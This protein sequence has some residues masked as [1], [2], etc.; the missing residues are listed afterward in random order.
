[1]LFG[2]IWGVR[3]FDMLLET[4]RESGL[5]L[6]WSCPMDVRVAGKYL[7]RRDLARSGLD[8]LGALPEEE[9]VATLRAA[10]FVVVTSGTLDERDDHP[11]ISRLSLPSRIVFAL[12]VAQPPILVL[13]HPDTAA[14]R[15]VVGN[16]IGMTAPYEPGAFREAVERIV[17][18]DVQREMRSR[19]A[20]MASRFSAAGAREWLWD[21]LANGGPADLRFEPPGPRSGS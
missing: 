15:F 20:A 9:F 1:L 13:G 3:W 14:A 18:P 2:N 6:A 5:R 7:S 17:Q 19:A 21:S 4:I 10:P 11:A 8:A 16:R 12:A